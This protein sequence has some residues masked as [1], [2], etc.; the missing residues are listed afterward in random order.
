M[1]YELLEEFNTLSVERLRIIQ[2]LNKAVSLELKNVQE[3]DNYESQTDATI[4]ISRL[5]WNKIDI[6]D[7]IEALTDEGVTI[8]SELNNLLEDFST[9]D[10]EIK[11]MKAD[12]S[13]YLSQEIGD[14]RLAE[15]LTKEWLVGARD[16]ESINSYM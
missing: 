10:S 7:V 13:N 1:S 6:I 11:S 5:K 16:L 2:E 9:V 3:F 8:P 15:S 12:V 4:L 14:S